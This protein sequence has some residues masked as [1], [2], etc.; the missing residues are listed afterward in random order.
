MPEVLVS[1]CV[2]FVK[3]L[4]VALRSKLAVFSCFDIAVSSRC[5]ILFICCMVVCVSAVKVGTCLEEEKT[6]EELKKF[7]QFYQCLYVY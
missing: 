7:I 1:E 4:R 2:A 3:P 6:H 5:G